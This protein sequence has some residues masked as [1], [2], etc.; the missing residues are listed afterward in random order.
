MRR[1][2]LRAVG[3]RRG[4]RWQLLNDESGQGIAEY[5]AIIAI[6]AIG[7][8][9]AVG[10]LNGK[11]TGLFSKT[12]NSVNQV[13]LGSGSHQGGGGDPGGGGLPGA[14]TNLPSGPGLAG[15]GVWA[16][17]GTVQNVGGSGSNNGYS[18]LAG[19]YS[20]NQPGSPAH[21]VH[22]GDSCTVVVNGVPFTGHW[23]YHQDI[24][25]PDS[26]WRV[27]GTSYN[28]ACLAISNEPPGN[29]SVI[30][31]PIGPVGGGTELTAT[32]AGYTG[33][34]WYEWDWDRNQAGNDPVC[35]G[36]YT[37]FPGNPDGGT[38]SSSSQHNPA[39]GHCYQVRVRARNAFGDAAT[40]SSNIVQVN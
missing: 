25:G 29:G 21:P 14:V 32:A 38:S 27:A 10:F 18:G 15:G 35:A 28:W 20:V 24:P 6:V 8:V 31:S 34:A 9:V 19:V 7:A 16:P 5:G 33:A 2:V 22:T 11:I 37:D 3:R 39:G 17:L 12:S 40:D 30:L 23:V 36:S 4:A 1:I 13:A 26:D